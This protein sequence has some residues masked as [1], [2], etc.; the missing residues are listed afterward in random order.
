MTT[1]CSIRMHHL[2]EL[3]IHTGTACNLECPFCLEGSR[4]GDTRLERIKLNEIKPYLDQAAQL[5]VRRFCFTGGEPLIV[6]D[7]VK[8]LEYALNL[9][10]CM[11]ISNGTA[12]LLK[13]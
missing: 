9:K 4:P 12:P 2:D 3:W 8:I 10:P 11:I 6:K 5:G 7:I 1:A 13:R